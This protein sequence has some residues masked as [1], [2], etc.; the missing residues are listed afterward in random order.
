MKIQALSI[1]NSEENLKSVMIDVNETTGGIS[2]P[3]SA[4]IGKSGK[5]K[6]LI[7]N[8][9][10]RCERRGWVRDRKSKSGSRKEGKKEGQR[11]EIERKEGRK[12]KGWRKEGRK[13]GGMEGRKE[14]KKKERKEGR[15]KLRQVMTKYRRNL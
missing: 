3:I 15:K 14:E 11:V 13:E 7:D 10:L 8:T 5:V 9:Y 6:L 2:L 12:R 1:S 4:L